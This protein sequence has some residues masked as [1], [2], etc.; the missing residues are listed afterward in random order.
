[1]AACGYRTR[2]RR[3]GSTPAAASKAFCIS[4][5][6]HILNRQSPQLLPRALLCKIMITEQQ[7]R[8]WIADRNVLQF[9]VSYDWK[10]KRE[11]VLALDKHECQK[12]KAR[13]VYTRATI[14]HHV[15]HLRDRPDLALSI[16]HIQPDGTKVRQLVSLCDR[17]HEEEHPER[18]KQY[19][20]QKPITEER[21]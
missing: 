8:Q 20:K 17:C 14:V 12:C 1:M 16:W 10:K 21:W 5:F 6:L 9:Y 4:L 15:K 2:D 19:R 18:L 7:I 11:E 13:G 3:A